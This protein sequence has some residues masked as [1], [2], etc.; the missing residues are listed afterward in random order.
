ME[1]RRVVRPY[2]NATTCKKTQ[3]LLF[4][5]EAMHFVPLFIVLSKN[6][7][8]SS[9]AGSNEACKGSKKQFL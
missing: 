2:V 4:Y 7:N 5:F 3:V 1:Q 6:N 8:A 9:S